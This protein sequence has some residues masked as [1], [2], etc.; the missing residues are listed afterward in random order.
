MNKSRNCIVEMCITVYY[1]MD[2]QNPTSHGWKRRL[3]GWFVTRTGKTSEEFDLYGRYPAGVCVET[4]AERGSYWQL[5]HAFREVIDI[6]KDS[7]AK[8]GLKEST[9]YKTAFSASSFLLDMQ[10]R[11]RESLNDI[12]ENNVISYF[13][14]EDGR[15]PLNGRYRDT[16]A[17]VFKSDLGIHTKLARRILT[18]IPVIRQ[19]GGVTVMRIYHSGFSDS[20]EAFVNSRKISGA[21][22]ETFFRLL[23]SS[24]ICTTEARFLMR[25]GIDF[26]QGVLDIQKSKGYNQHYVVLHQSMAELLERYDRAADRLCPG[27]AYFFESPAGQPYSC[28]WVSYNFSVLWEKAK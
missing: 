13:V 21:W 18:Y 22:N 9:L 12:T 15:S 4:S 24:G 1:V 5:N 27:R 25:R 26:G 3:T 16:V 20:I 19:R 6:Y 8:R 14:C 7:G 28:A 10:N 17:S 23:Y 11:G 2:I